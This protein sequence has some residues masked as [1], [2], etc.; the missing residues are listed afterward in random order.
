MA[1][2][3]LAG[4][5]NTCR[6]D[7]SDFCKLGGHGLGLPDVCG[8][9]CELGFCDGREGDVCF[10]VA[11]LDCSGWECAVIISVSNEQEEQGRREGLR[12]ND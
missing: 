4:S 3:A 2:P 12:G 8:V 10:C 7:G 5:H 11:G 9:D 1:T 6:C